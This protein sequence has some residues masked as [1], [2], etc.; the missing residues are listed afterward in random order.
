VTD[1]G[2]HIGAADE[3]NFEFGLQAILDRASRLIDVGSKPTK[4]PRAPA[5]V[6]PPRRRSKSV[7]RK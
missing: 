3:T 5:K 1:S 4:A 2:Q 7:A 6:S